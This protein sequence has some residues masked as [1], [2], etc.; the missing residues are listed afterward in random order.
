MSAKNE[1]TK[2]ANDYN[3]HNIIQKIVAKSII[4]DIKKDL[5]PLPKRI[6]EIGC[7]SGQIYNNI[8]WDIESYTAIDFSNNMC[9]L[10]PK[11]KKIDVK[12][13]DFDSNDFFEYINQSNYDLIISSSAMQWS[14]D[15]YKLIN[16]LLSVSDKL[17]CSLFTSNTFK[18]IQKLSNSKSPIASLDYIKDSFRDFTNVSFETYNYNLSFNNKKELFDYI[19]KSGVSGGNNLDF[20]NAKK[21]YKEYN[22]DYLEFEVV[23]IKAF[24]KS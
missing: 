23:F 1:F 12:C 7:G 15:L 13:F 8:D 2:Y 5:E 4:R 10:H 19:K 20:K 21:L 17:Y 18:T 22:L 24:S 3:N 16:R 9:E 14:K 11:N 6:L